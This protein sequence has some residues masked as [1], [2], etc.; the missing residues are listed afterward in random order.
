[1]LASGEVAT[2]ALFQPEESIE[3]AMRESIMKPPGIVVDTNHS[4]DSKLR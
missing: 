3:Q 2:G 4:Y 1:M